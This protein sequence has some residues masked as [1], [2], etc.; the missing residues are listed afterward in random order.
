MSP[1]SLSR[2]RGRG[3]TAHTGASPAGRGDEE[4]Q[5]AVL[6]IGF[7]AISLL[8]L[9]VVM[10]ASS[11]YIERK[12]LLS[13]ADGAAVAAADTFTLADVETGEGG[14]VPRLSDGAVHSAV[15]R[16]LAETGA[17][18]RFSGLAISG[19][20][21]SP[22][23]RTAHVELSAVVHPPMVNFLVPDGVP[24]TVFSDARSEL[25]R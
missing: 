4:G 21:G 5:V 11:V 19:G 20:T 10:A 9:T 23:S 25:R 3:G 17:A 7:V 16:Y 1:F 18:G 8:I 15:Q 24:I 13:V 14:P 6:I 2:P 22:E 12:K